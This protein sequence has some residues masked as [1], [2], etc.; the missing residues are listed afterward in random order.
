LLRRLILAV[1]A[2]LAVALG[3]LGAGWIALLVANSSTPSPAARSTGHDGLWLGHAWV[4]G[5]KTQADIAALALQLRGGQ[6]R[7]LFVHVGP[8]A[9]DGTLD[10]ALR[11]EA[12]W[13]VTALH[14]ARPGVRV[15]AWLGDVVGPGRMD[16]SGAATRGRIVSSARQVLADGFD[17]IHYDLE[18]VRSGDQGFLRLLTATRAE[19]GRQR[20]ILS[21]AASYLEPVRGIGAVLTVLPAHPNLWSPSYLH[22]VA[23]RADEIALMA[24][25]TG[26]WSKD[27]YGGY[28]RRQTALALGAVPP[29]VTLLIGLPAYHEDS[30]RHH[31]SAETVAA[32]LHGIRLALGTAASSRPFGVSLYVDFAATSQDWRSYD[33]DWANSPT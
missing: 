30:F 6:I 23:T 7:D 5:Q 2:I 11:P 14:Q 12:R 16:L 24:Y 20:A 26:I 10:P 4:D 1:A 18:P 27:A 32:S 31:A 9:D 15:Q 28:I 13:L 21:V 8:L 25:D 22:Q 17:G 29:D 33:D 3:L 19:T